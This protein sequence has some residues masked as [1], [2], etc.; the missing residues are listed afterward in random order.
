MPFFKIAT[1]NVNSLR[2]R[3]SHVMNWV[4]SNQPD[5]LALQETKLSDDDF[6]QDFLHEF[7]YQVI[8]SGEK[9]YNGVAFLSR[10]K[11]DD[12]LVDIPGVLDPQRR[13]LGGTYQD[14]RVI[15]LYVPNGQNVLSTKYEYKL[16]WLKNINLFLKA[17]LLKYPKMIVL[18]DFNIAPAEIDVYNPKR[19]Q[20]KVLFS[21]PERQAFQEIIDLGFQDCFRTLNPNQVEFSWWDYRLLAFQRNWGLRIDHILVSEFLSSYCKTCF[22]DKVTRTWER[23]SDHV[24]VIAK[25]AL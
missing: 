7:H 12:I 2:V 21:L 13:V 20:G 22:V 3:R 6:P 8:A 17:E 16:N 18:G 1:W 19:W 10:E 24:P 15:N 9:S 14:I 11:L 4:E 23:P 5:L 25:F